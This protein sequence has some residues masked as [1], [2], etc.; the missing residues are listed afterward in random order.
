MKGRASLSS[1]MR[2]LVLQFISLFF[3]IA[4]LCA[5]MNLG[6]TLYPGQSLNSSQTLVSRGSIFQ[7]GFISEASPSDDG[8]ENTNTSVRVQN[9]Y[10]AI[11]FQK[12]PG[13]IIWNANRENPINDAVFLALNLS[14]N[15]YLNLT[16]SN[17]SFQSLWSPDKNTD[18]QVSTVLVLLDSGNLVLRDHN[19]LSRVMWQ[20]FDHPTDTWLPGAKLGFNKV[21]G[22]NMFLG[23]PG[24]SLEIDPSRSDGF[25]MKKDD[26][27]NDYYGI[28][29]T[30]LG[31]QQPDDSGLVTFHNTREPY[32]FIQLLWSQIT[33]RLVDTSDALETLW[34]A[35]GNC[36]YN[37][38]SSTESDSC[39]PAQALCSDLSILHQTSPNNGS[40][41]STIAG[42]SSN[43][44]LNCQ[45]TWYS[46]YYNTFYLVKNIA[47]YPDDPQPMMVK[48]KNECETACYDNCLCSAYVYQS[49]RNNCNLW[50]E[51]LQN[52]FTQ[53]TVGDNFI[54]I[55]VHNQKKHIPIWVFT[56]IISFLAPL[57]VFISLFCWRNIESRLIIKEPNGEHVLILY[58]YWQIK[59]VTR[60][61]SSKLGEGGF[62]IVFKG[63]MTSSTIVA[64]KK[65]KFN[66]Y[67]EKEFRTEVRT[68]GMIHHTNLVKLHGFC[69]TGAWKMLVYEYMP[70]GSL[71]TYLFSNRHGVINWKTRYQI[72]LGV[73]KGLTYLHEECIDCIIHC[74]I[75]PEN[76]LLDANFCPKIADF[77]MAKLLNRDMS[78]VLTTMRGTIGYLAPEWLS[79]QPITQKADVYSFG[80]MLFEIISGKRNKENIKSGEYTYFPVHAAIKINHGELLCL[81]DDKLEG[82]VNIEEL[83]RACKVACWCIQDWETLRPCMGEV[84]RML[85][86][87]VN[88]EM[89]PIPRGLQ[90]LVDLENASSYYVRA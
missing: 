54:N 30:W 35:P 14:S 64:V 51:D 13:T 52:S 41:R 49:D 72:M 65:L 2:V 28:F 84:V 79:G 7:L 40:G 58:S 56:L 61:F 10:L 29:P 6:D 5:A 32:L 4:N 19:N 18:K 48:S 24:F 15:G 43:I 70:Y 87:T 37:F 80:M 42:C 59:A 55:R 82:I 90:Y 66:N 25:I 23:C 74:D 85:E 53:D 88:V 76:I 50:F 75:K 86:G 27:S 67:D 77:G 83:D 20:S 21:T 68:I 63:W 34:Y 16:Q 1:Q 8:I 69:S 38:Y 62:G 78:R 71:D 3:L 57:F 11:S 73:A 12:S 22:K 36:M 45:T 39:P 60:N 26:A 47:I 9:Y 17:F 33:I 89:P 81:L 46:R 44:S 31:I